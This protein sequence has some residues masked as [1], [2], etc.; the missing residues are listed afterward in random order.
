MAEKKEVTQK[1]NLIVPFSTYLKI[2]KRAEE[3]T[4]KQQKFVGMT[5]VLND[6]II[7]AFK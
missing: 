2:K 5:D 1:I 4:K 7:P 6:V 3:E